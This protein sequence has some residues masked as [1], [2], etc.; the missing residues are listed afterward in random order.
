MGREGIPVYLSRLGFMQLYSGPLCWNNM[1][2]VES[3]RTKKVKNLYQIFAILI[4]WLNE[5]SKCVYFLIAG[6]KRFCCPYCDKRFM[7][8]DHLNKHARRHPEFD[9]TVLQRSRLKKSSSSPLPD[10]SKETDRER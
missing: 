8:S 5:C 9:P 4:T 10:N 1:Y 3:L 6:E 2:V 7:R